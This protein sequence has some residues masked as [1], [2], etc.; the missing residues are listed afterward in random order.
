V[1]PPPKGHGRAPIFCLGEAYRTTRRAD[2]KMD[3]AKTT[4]AA[5]QAQLAPSQAG[6]WVGD[7]T[8]EGLY[9]WR[10]ASHPLQEGLAGEMEDSHMCKMHL[11]KINIGFVFSVKNKKHTDS[12]CFEI[13]RKTK[14][15]TLLSLSCRTKKGMKYWF[16]QSTVACSLKITLFVK[17]RKIK[18]SLNTLRAPWS[19]DLPAKSKK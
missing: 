5:H 14:M 8:T 15:R 16:I 9:A 17:R 1:V 12:C 4:S 11:V 18:K 2:G 10:A 6:P 7:G 3:T 13:G 19:L